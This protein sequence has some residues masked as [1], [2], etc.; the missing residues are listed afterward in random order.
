MACRPAAPNHPLKLASSALLA[1]LDG[2][3][4]EPKASFHL[5]DLAPP[6]SWLLIRADRAQ[7]R[8]D[9][10]QPAVDTPAAHL[11]SCQASSALPKQQ[12]DGKQAGRL[13]LFLEARAGRPEVQ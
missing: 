12:T 2:K 3:Q 7:A 13:R 10:E 6:A 4:V 5:R 8:I 1:S 9:V 11:D